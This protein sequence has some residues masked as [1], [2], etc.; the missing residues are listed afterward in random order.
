MTIIKLYL[1]IL[2]IRRNMV[3]ICRINK[4]N[5]SFW[6]R[7]NTQII[8]KMELYYDININ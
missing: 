4:K 7:R 8:S 2:N 6:N 3:T 5:H 1:L